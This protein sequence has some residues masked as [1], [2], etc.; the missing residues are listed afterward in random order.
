[1]A[2]RPQ[3]NSEIGNVG[4]PGGTPV[5]MG[6][7]LYDL[8]LGYGRNPVNAVTSPAVAASPWVYTNDSAYDQDVIVSGGTV[9]SVEF[10]R[11][12]VFYGTTG[13]TRLSPGDALRVTYTVAPALRIIPR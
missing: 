10:G 7:R 4:G 11:G 8:L 13:L 9:S 12:G 2:T 1:M 3:L 6:R 5:T